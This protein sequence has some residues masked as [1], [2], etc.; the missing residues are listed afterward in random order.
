MPRKTRRRSSIRRK[1]VTKKSR[2][3]GWNPFKTT[4]DKINE[5]FK[6]S[7]G[8]I[9]AYPKL[10]KYYI[11]NNTKDFLSA[12]ADLKTKCNDIGI[13]EKEITEIK[14]KIR[15]INSRL[16]KTGVNISNEN[17]EKNKVNSERKKA[18]LDEK[19]LADK[20]NLDKKLVVDKAKLDEKL[21]VDKAKLDENLVVD[22]KAINTEMTYNMANNVN[23]STIDLELRLKELNDELYRL[24]LPS[25]ARLFKESDKNYIERMAIQ[26]GM[27]YEKAEERYTNAS[28]DP[29]DSEYSTLNQIA[30][31]AEVRAKREAKIKNQNN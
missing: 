30:Y 23:I 10:C 20:A 21:V 4:E 31:D 17:L 25:T 19:F 11:N 28:Y 6:S 5:E 3:G 26:D 22:K 18:E 29:R 13:K 24:T 7:E 27:T 12:S 1:R 2:V 8:D 15:M 16:P 9:E 14:E